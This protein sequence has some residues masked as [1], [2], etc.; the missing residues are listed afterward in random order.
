MN[1]ST[2]RWTCRAGYFRGLGIRLLHGRFVGEDDNRGSQPVVI[3]K[4][5]FVRAA[6]GTEHV[7]GRRV[8]VEQLPQAWMT[9]SGVVDDLRMSS[10][11]AEAPPV[12]YVRYLLSGVATFNN[13]VVRTIRDPRNTMPLVREAVRSVSPALAVS[14]I[15][16]MEERVARAV[17]PRAF[18]LWLIGLFSFVALVLAIVGIYGL[19]SESVASRTTEIGVRMALGARR[20]EVVRLVLGRSLLMTTVGIVLGLAGAAGAIRYLESMLFR[21]TPFDPTTF[22]AVPLTFGIVAALAALVP[23]HASRVDPVI[24]LRCE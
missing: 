10:L 1:R 3:V 12:V 2:A 23:A 16:T 8:R 15:A 14:H 17:A 6:W 19:I 24:A 9:V 20:V 18:N 4:R 22:V 5:A 11:E 7:I 13:Y 21:I